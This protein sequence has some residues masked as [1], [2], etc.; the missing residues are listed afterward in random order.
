[1]TVSA[2]TIRILLQTT[3]PLA[4]DDWHVGRFSLLA[5]HLRDCGHSVDCRNRRPNPDGDDDVLSALARSSY[6]ELWLFAA[7]V[8]NG[9][10]PRDLEGINAFRRRGG[11]L[12]T[13]RDH[14]DLGLC[15]CGIG[16]VGEANYFHRCHCESDPSRQ[17]ADD[18]ETPS[19]DWPN[20]RSG[21]NGDYQ[22]IHPAGPV[23]PVLRRATR[24]TIEYFPAHPHEGA[25]G[26]DECG[27][28]GRAIA[29]A[30]SQATGRV[31]NLV[32]A[33]E[34]PGDS[35]GRAL[36]HSSFHHFADYNWNPRLSKPSFVTEPPGDG[37]LREPQAATDIRTYAANAARWLAG[38]G[39]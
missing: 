7:D 39:S 2:R 24:E 10:T 23:H 31:F 26:A 17:A 14:Q 27:A 9:L 1:M 12:L 34:P 32:V 15:L 6:D 21:R 38:Q 30:T 37:M 19:I 18:R 8:D 4:E 25:V 35:R 13:A 29:T 33:I 3:I 16:A 36:V 20:Y 22:R 11:G 28:Q 5:R